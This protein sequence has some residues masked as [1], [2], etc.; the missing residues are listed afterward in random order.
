M[1]E[2]KKV[3]LGYTKLDFG[4]VCFKKEKKAK[5]SSLRLI[6]K[7]LKRKRMFSGSC[8]MLPTLDV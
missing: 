1:R 2:E 3:I 5:E 4:L 6:L 8:P 7:S